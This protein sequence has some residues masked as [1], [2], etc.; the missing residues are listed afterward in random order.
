MY[1]LNIAM[2]KALQGSRPSGDRYIERTEGH[3]DAHGAIL[4][5]WGVPYNIVIARNG[6]KS[7]R[8]GK[9]VVHRQWFIWSSG[10]NRINEWG[11]GDDQFYSR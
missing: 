1:D 7:V 5:P 11:S 2:M 8:V 9:F 3:L 10:A 4:D 6:R